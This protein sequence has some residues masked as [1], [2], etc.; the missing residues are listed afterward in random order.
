MSRPRYAKLRRDIR[1]ARGRMALMV[2][3][4]A[5][6]LAAI[7][8]MLTARTVVLR[9]AAANYVA[10]NPASATLDVEGGVSPALLDQVRTRPGIAD[11]AARQ[12]VTARVRV[13]DSWRR[14]LLFVIDA[15]DPLRIARFDI[16]HGAWPPPADGILLER[17]A[18]AVLGD[19]ATVAVTAPNGQAGSFTV[20]GVVH[21]AALAPGTQER[22]GYGYLT[23]AG[24]A[25]LGLTPDRDQLKIIVSGDQGAVDARARE[26]AAWLTAGGH[27]VHAINAPP[28]SR[29]PHQNQVDTITLLFLGFAVAALIL[30]AVVV[31]TTLGGMLA[32]QTRQIGVLKTLG[33]TT[34]Q[35]LGTYLLLA[36]AVAAAAVVLAVVPSVLAGLA[37]ADMM[38]SLLNLD[39]IDASVPGWVFAV[40]A[41]S[42]L[43]VPL[44]V[45]LV[46]LTRA[47]RT[48][49]RAALDHRGV[50]ASRT[51]GRPSRIAGGN[52][53]LSFAVRNA[54]RRRGRLALTLALLTAGGALFTGGLNTAG[55]WNA[56]V[57]DGLARRSYDAEILLSEPVSAGRITALLRDV[58]GLTSAEPLSVL[59]AVPVRGGQVEVSRTYPDGGHGALN[60]I[61]L[62][63]ESALID[64][65][66]LGGRWLRGGDRDGV[67]LN[68][69]AVTRLGNPA[70]GEQVTLSVEGRNVVLRVVGVVAEVGGPAAAYTA[71]DPATA[72]ATAVRLAYD[73]PRVLGKAEQ[74]FATANVQTQMIVPV[75]EF[76]TAIDQHVLIFIQI[77]VVLAVLMAVVGALGLASAMGI[78]VTERTREFGVM[79][80]IGATPSTVC[81]TLVLEGLAIGLAGC[82]IALA[83]GVPLSAGVGDFL[84]TLSFGLPLPLNLSVTGMAVWVMLSLTAA[85]AA[86][87]TAARRASRLTI[88][89]ILAYE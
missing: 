85:A 46:P 17:S 58:G 11:A 68:Q 16:E 82:L 13:G 25:R 4:V 23:P 65:E 61:A 34:S 56:W 24:L 76:R 26:L 32:Q 1:V 64:F 29:H 88:R 5:I 89:E 81:L 75:E 43:G 53:L 6:S 41:A 27:A 45:A 73:D 12:T 37:L 9:E 69:G 66:L 3:A 54:L 10:T 33:A 62:P 14:M 59:P 28:A 60:L 70:L 39:I 35:I 15:D 49:V 84:G 38:A 44:L 20:T 78:A 22:T 40:L 71:S 83:A 19:P 51:G 31:A 55:A 2:V 36:L 30:A 87:L 74:A 67:V 42:G 57:E 80:T 50:T 21:D 7:G 47:A 52:R 63:A 72:T 79:Q 86:T 8:A 77:L 18:L 48:T